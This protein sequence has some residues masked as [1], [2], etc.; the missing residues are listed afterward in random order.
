MPSRVGVTRFLV[1]LTAIVLTKALEMRTGW[2]D[3]V[4]LPGAALAGTVLLDRVAL[5][6]PLRL[7]GREWLGA[8]AAA[9]ALAAVIAWV[10]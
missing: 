7:N 4:T 3:Y 5:P 1:I 6:P 9:L 10:S 8:A 2:P